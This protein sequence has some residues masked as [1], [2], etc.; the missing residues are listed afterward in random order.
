M[1]ELFY[2]QHR[3]SR[4]PDETVLDAMLRN[5]VQVRFSCRAGTCHTCMMRAVSGD[6]PAEARKGLRPEL[7][8]AG[9]FL[10][11]R[12]KPDG[13]LKIEPSNPA[14]LQVDAYVTE[15]THMGEDVWRIRFESDSGTEPLAGQHVSLLDPDG[16]VRP[17]SL[18]NRPGHD[19]FWEIHVRRIPDG[20][21]SSWLCDA[22]MPGD[23]LPMLPPAGNFVNRVPNPGQPLVLIATGTGLAPL[24]PILHESLE[25]DPDAVIWLFHGAR[26]KSGLY[27]DEY[28]RSLA[29]ST[30]RF[31]YRACCT[32]ESVNEPYLQGRVTEWLRQSLPDLTGFRVF[33]AGHKVMVE[34]ARSVCA[35]LGVMVESD[36]R[37]DA[38]TFTHEQD[39]QS[40][41][42]GVTS[43]S[44]EV[45][46]PDPEL[47][48]ALGNGAILREVLHDFYEMAFAD[49]Y[50]GPYFSGVTQQR[51]REKQFSFLRSLILDTR[52]YLGQR[53][54]NAHHWMVISDELFDYRLGLME[55]C[56]RSHG[57]TDSWIR[58]WHVFEEFFRNDIVK[59]S[60]VARIMNGKELP[61]DGF[62]EDILEEGALCDACGREMASGSKVRFHVRIGAV[63][64]RQCSGTGEI[65][66]PGNE[67]DDHRTRQSLA[68]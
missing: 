48:S 55:Q 54:R 25:E 21:V 2:L 36:F 42:A 11:C 28:L 24:L 61:L 64:C 14:D 12:C 20:K 8:R 13:T 56:M 34:E 10:P 38:F 65:P 15:K 46:P 53:P 1:T 18:A 57:L 43:N 22:V 60:P 51:L 68:G 62:E 17:Y 67:N 45:P 47:W 39:H 40:S 7:V 30:S 41:R 52:D 31:N 49:P 4:H 23:T 19:G 16:T 6:V 32:R 9:Y 5:G 29:N 50:L 35:E 63:Y 59:A 27:R 58:R 26:S 66:D 3:L 33:A 37:A 44:R